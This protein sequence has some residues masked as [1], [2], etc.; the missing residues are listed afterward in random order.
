MART[1]TYHLEIQ[2]ASKLAN[3]LNTELDYVNY[4][5]TV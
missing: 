5:H 4:A 1:T 3:K 2:Q